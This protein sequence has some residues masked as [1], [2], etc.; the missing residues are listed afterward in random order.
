MGGASR[1]HVHRGRGEGG[2]GKRRMHAVPRIPLTGG[3]HR[4]RNAAPVIAP[5]ADGNAIFN[6]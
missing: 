1:R 3:D 5:D 6:R 2:A 4:F